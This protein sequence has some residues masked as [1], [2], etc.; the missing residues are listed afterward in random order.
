MKTAC[1]QKLT[2]IRS[3][4]AVQHPIDDPTVGNIYFLLVALN[5][6]GR[7][8]VVGGV[9]EGLAYHVIRNVERCGYCR[10]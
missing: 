5:I 6:Y 3:L 10:P 1:A 8:G 7:G 4:F 2:K 9:P